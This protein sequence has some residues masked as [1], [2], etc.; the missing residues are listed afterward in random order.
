MAELKGS[1]KQIRWAEKIRQEK[2]ED[3]SE[4]VLEAEEVSRK[5]EIKEAWEGILK[6]QDQAAFWIENRNSRIHFFCNL[7]AEKMGIADPEEKEKIFF[8]KFKKE[9]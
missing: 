1:E 4:L 8:L 6:E 5:N 2:I 9:A 3:F 7:V